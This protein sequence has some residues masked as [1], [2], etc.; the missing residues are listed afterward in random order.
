MLRFGKRLVVEKKMPRSFG[1]ASRML[2]AVCIEALDFGSSICHCLKLTY[3]K[4]TPL[5]VLKNAHLIFLS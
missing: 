2:E 3:L 5:T 1:K 4:E